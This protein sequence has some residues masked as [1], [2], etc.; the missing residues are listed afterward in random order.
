LAALPALPCGCSNPA[1]TLLGC[2]WDGGDEAKMQASFGWGKARFG[3][4]QD[5]QK[6]AAGMG[7]PTGAGLA[8]LARHVLRLEI[9]K[10]KKVGIELA[11][12]AEAVWLGQHDSD[13]PLLYAGRAVQ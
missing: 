10:H 3:A 5:V 12:A 2:G 7:L 9:S 8:S 4:F 11:V 1:I 13:A 6:V